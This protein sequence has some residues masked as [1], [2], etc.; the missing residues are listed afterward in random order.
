MPGE[1]RRG[2]KTNLSIFANNNNN[3]TIPI[4][5][6]KLA[7]TA[8]SIIN[9]SDNN[10]T[11]G[12]NTS[13]EEMQLKLNQI[14]NELQTLTDVYS[15]IDSSSSDFNKQKQMLNIKKENLKIEFRQIL[16]ILQLKKNSI[17]KTIPSD[18]VKNILF[19]LFKTTL[20]KFLLIGRRIGSERKS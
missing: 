20:V 5:S 11:T 7:S 3:N 17:H 8:S 12:E 14:H 10:T 13:I 19:K 4:D 2:I 16:H 6:N 18:D 9:P 15:K 1:I